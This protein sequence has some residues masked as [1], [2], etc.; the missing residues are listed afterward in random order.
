MACWG[1]HT[2]SHGHASGNRGVA[3]IPRP[4]PPLPPRHTLTR[5]VN[6]HS[7]PADDG[8]KACCDE[9]TPVGLPGSGLEGRQRSGQ[10]AG[11][12]A[13]RVVPP[14]CGGLAGRRAE[15]QR[16]FGGGGGMRLH[17]GTVAEAW[18]AHTRRDGRQVALQLH[19]CPTTGAGLPPS[20][21]VPG[22]GG[23]GE[24]AAGAAAAVLPCQ[25]APCSQLGQVETP[26]ACRMTN[27]SAA[28]A[29]CR[30]VG[31][32]S[33]CT[34]LLSVGPA[35]TYLHSTYGLCGICA[36]ASGRAGREV[37]LQHEAAQLADACIVSFGEPRVAVHTGWC[38]VSLVK[39]RFPSRDSN[40]RGLRLAP[41]LHSP[42][43]DVA[44]T[45]V[46]DWRLALQCHEGDALGSP[47]PLTQ[48][49]LD[50]SCWRRAHTT[51]A[52]RCHHVKLIMIR[53]LLCR[54]APTA[55]STNN[56]AT[57]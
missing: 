57:P 4:P 33:C 14:V 12:A 48:E 45:A 44:P 49:D 40:S 36:R 22:G 5:V 28:V 32:V 8:A 11:W 38:A 39:W 55:F 31:L 18:H 43:C 54:H 13:C 17:G 53:S 50:L 15:A 56:T 2:T 52:L 9:V 51:Q 21:P 20:I 19:D 3:P 23:E 34:R 37:Q 10:S 1:N 29:A 25:L 41:L 24:E 46:G 26:H 30:V 42:P 6:V 35:N 47:V 16:R 7:A 27:D